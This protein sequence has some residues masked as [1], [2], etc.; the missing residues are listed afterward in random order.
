MLLENQLI[1]YLFYTNQFMFHD[2]NTFE[3]LLIRIPWFGLLD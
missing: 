3:W 2:H 1:L